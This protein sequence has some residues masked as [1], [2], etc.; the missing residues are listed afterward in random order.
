[1]RR[2]TF[3]FV[4]L[5]A[6][7]GCQEEQAPGYDVRVC[8]DLTVPEEIDA[9]RLT[10]Y[11]EDRTEAWSGIVELES[12]DDSPAV[13]MVEDAGPVVFPDVVQMPAAEE[14]G[15]SDGW[16]GG[17]CEQASECGHGQAV[18]LTSGDGFPGGL[19]TKTC[20]RTCPNRAETPAVLC[21]AEFGQA[22][23]FEEGMCVQVCDF[24]ALPPTGCRPDYVCTPKARFDNGNSRDVCL[25]EQLVNP[26][27]GV[28]DAMIVPDAGVADAGSPMG[29]PERTTARY[30][31]KRVP[32]PPNAWIRAQGL[33]RGVVRVTSEIRPAGKNRVPLVADCLGVRC[34]IGK[35]C[36]GGLCETVPVGGECP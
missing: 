21:I 3:L 22:Y 26:D 34:P 33:S 4:T 7:I 8:G 28:P 10:V 29:A 32:N 18:C 24:D 15:P 16:L 19:C 25:P 2:T 31:E 27:A 20:G 5:L 11:R 13:S 35:T 1:M 23:G 12:P 14:P 36:M 6:I 30:A 17:A 9:I